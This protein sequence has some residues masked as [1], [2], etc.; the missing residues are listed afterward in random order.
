MKIIWKI[1]IF[2]SSETEM[3]IMEKWCLSFILPVDL[4]HVRVG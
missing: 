4:D 2:S 3:L 1:M